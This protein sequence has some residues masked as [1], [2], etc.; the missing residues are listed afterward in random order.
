MTLCFNLLIG[1]SLS[2]L[3]GCSSQLRLPE[4]QPDGLPAAWQ[5]AKHWPTSALPPLTTELLALLDSPVLRRQVE[6]ALAAN[7]DLRQT[8]LRLQ[9][10]GLLTRQAQAGRVPELSLNLQSQRSYQTQQ[11]NHSHTLGLELSWEL[12]VW[13][14]LADQ[15]RLAEEEHEQQRLDYQAARDSLAAKVMQ[16]WIELSLREQQMAIE[17][18]WLAS[19]A[20]T[21]SSSR[22]RYRQGLGSQ[23]DWQTA[24]AQLARAQ[25]VQAATAQSQAEA[26]RQ[27][28][29]WQG[30]AQ[31]SPQLTS[32][33]LTHDW[34]LSAPPALVPAQW[35]ARRV[36]IQAAYQG[37]RIRAR[38][39]ALAEKAL[40]PGFNL[41]ASLS[42][43]RPDLGEL[44][45]GS[46][47]WSV[48][49]RITAPLFNGGRLRRQ[50][51]IADL[52]V[53]VSYQRYQHILLTAL[54]EV[55]NSLSRE[56]SLAQQQQHYQQALQH[57]ELSASHY[58]QRYRQGLVDILDW[59]SA[60]QNLYSTRL[61]LLQTQQARLVNR[62]T[63]G[64]ALGMGV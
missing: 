34:Q 4:A 10:Q 22:E 64:L 63:L 18:Q 28:A 43:A 39:A 45:S 14:R 25:A 13:G 41:S 46:L 5:E 40:L 37:I 23:A 7:L 61:Q 51:E 17:Q 1:L 21:A 2:L 60:E 47:A 30:K 24:Q 38:Q 53:E 3:L 11:F 12:D 29:L 62:I 31:S 9:Q 16:L 19:L 49:N 54:H 57:A 44:L 48:L 59:L 32:Q 56:A 15:Q 52:E 8:A 58:Q 26:W 36:D 35:L 50:A 27:L 33:A 20:L 42:Q 6:Q 55:E